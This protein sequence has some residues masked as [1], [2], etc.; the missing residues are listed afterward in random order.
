MNK[1]VKEHMAPMP[2]TGSKNPFFL[3]DTTC[4]MANPDQLLFISRVT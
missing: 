4:Y 1:T 3:V 2:I